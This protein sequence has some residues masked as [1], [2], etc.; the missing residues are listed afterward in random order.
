MWSLYAVTQLIKTCS[1]YCW[2]ICLLISGSC[3]LGRRQSSPRLSAPCYLHPF[4][5]FAERSVCQVWRDVVTVRANVS[6][7]QYILCP[8]SP[9]LPFITPLSA[10]SP[11]PM[12][13]TRES[14]VFS[15]SAAM[16]WDNVGGQWSRQGE[17]WNI[18]PHPLPL[19]SCWSPFSLPM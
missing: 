16:M 17:Y 10:A 7:I 3:A 14:F 8:I 2:S 4:F 1:I 18:D 5:F 12:F 11:A 15:M 9:Q 13:S 19:S 6:N